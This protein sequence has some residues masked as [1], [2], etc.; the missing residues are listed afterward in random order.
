MIDVKFVVAN[1]TT[2]FKINKEI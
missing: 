1:K 2:L